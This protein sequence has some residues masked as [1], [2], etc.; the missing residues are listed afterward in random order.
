[1][2]K[3]VDSKVGLVRRGL[4]LLAIFVL[5]IALFIVSLTA[6]FALP[7]GRIIA[8]L[9]P[10]VT[11]LRSEGLYP[12]LALGNNTYRLDNLDDAYWLDIAIVTQPGGPLVNAMGMFRGVVAGKDTIATLAH[13]IAGPR[14]APGPYAYYWHGYQLFLRPALLFLNYGEMRYLNILLMGMLAAIVALAAARKTDDVAAGTFIFALLFCGFWA[15]PLTINYSSDAYLMLLGSLVVLLWADR[16]TFRAYAIETF[17]VIGMLTAFFDNLTNPM[18]TL[19]VPLGFALIMFARQAPLDSAWRDVTFAAKMVVAWGVGYVGAWLSKWFIGSAVL[20]QNV[21]AG[22]VSQFLFRAG[23]TDKKPHQLDA[24]I[25]NLKDLFPLIRPHRLAGTFL[26]VVALIV[27]VALLIWF[28]RPS[29]QIRRMLPV[30]TVAPLPFVYY[31]VASEHTWNH[32]WLTYR[33]LVVTV[34]SVVYFV[35]A[36]VDFERLGRRLGLV[37]TPEPDDGVSPGGEQLP[38]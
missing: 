36:A 8:N 26:P 12:L 16:P 37:A 11:L 18:I 10:S 32:N 9:K 20:Q 1:V 34:F 33:S 35:L 27:V 22:G 19:G 31:I 30:L 38:A 15:V 5:G 24:I 14:E 2:P 21:V 25:W 28:R 13:D 6:V 4:R 3:T 7:Q 23:A 17:L 29:S